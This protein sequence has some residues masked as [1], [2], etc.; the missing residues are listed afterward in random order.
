MILE[1]ILKTNAVRILAKMVTVFVIVSLATSP[2]LIPPKKTEAILA[3]VDAP[4]T[5]LTSAIGAVHTALTNSLVVKEYIMDTIL[6]NLIQIVK[7]QIIRSTINWINSGFEGSPAFLENPGQFFKDIADETLGSFLEGTEFGFLCSPFQ[8]QIKLALIKKHY[9]SRIPSCTLSGALN[10]VRNF[11]DF[12]SVDYGVN[13]RNVPGSVFK[14]SEWHGVVQPEGNPYGAYAAA[15]AEASLRISTSRGTI[16]KELDLGDGLLSFKD[17]SNVDAEAN[18]RAYTGTPEEVAKLKAQGKKFAR[19]PGKE[20]CKVKTPGSVIA[21]QTNTVLGIPVATLITADEINEIISALLVQLLQQVLGSDGLSGASQSNSNYGGRSYLDEID[22]ES[23]STLNTNIGT[24]NE[25]MNKSS[26]TF[27]EYVQIK[28]QSLLRVNT[29]IGL[30][31]QVIYACERNNLPTSYRGPL[32]IN[33]AQAIAASSTINTILNPIKA[34]LENEIKTANDSR[35]E[36]DNIRSD[37][38]ALNRGDT[39]G[40]ALLFNQYTEL[41]KPSDTVSIFS[42]GTYERDVTLPQQ[43][44]PIDANAQAT[45]TSCNTIP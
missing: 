25:Q 40:F 15:E 21:A 39:N 1:R 4:H 30:Q 10:N 44:N 28:N 41:I 3:V 18:N 6:Y 33:S 31:N 16:Q 42:E 34:R 24:L 37:I 32:N 45:I 38:N 22:R 36:I 20:N 23:N 11:E 35:G 12:V 26:N 14:W 8:I 43:L 9:G 27:G 19:G 2:I 29:S 5:A 13:Q 17:C 7:Q